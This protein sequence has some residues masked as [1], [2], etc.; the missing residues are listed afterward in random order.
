MWGFPVLFGLVLTAC[1]C[2]WLI[3]GSSDDAALRGSSCDSVILLG[4]SIFRGSSFV[5]PGSKVYNHGVNGETTGEILA[6]LKRGAVLRV[7]ADSKNSCLFI[8]AGTND[9]AENQGPYSEAQTLANLEEM[10]LWALLHQTTTLRVFLCSVLPVVPEYRWSP[11]VKDVDQKIKSLN[12]GISNLAQKVSVVFLDLY[13]AMMKNGA[14]SGLLF[15]DGVHP[16]ARGYQ[17][18]QEALAAAMVK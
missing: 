9:V 3:L 14:N 2:L 16:N 11:H 5:L 17:V 4:D 1:V 18:M 15:F 10:I 8:L 7:D 13:V 12:R 6:R